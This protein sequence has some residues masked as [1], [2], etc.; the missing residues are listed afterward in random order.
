MSHETI[1]KHGAIIE[2]S[3][4]IAGQN[5]SITNIK[6]TGSIST[7][8]TTV[9]T[10]NVI[11]DTISALEIGDLS[12]VT[13]T[14]LSDNDILVYSA[15]TWKNIQSDTIGETFYTKTESDS[16]FINASGD[17]MTGILNTIGI[18]T[19]GDT[20]ITGNII[21]S[22]N[23]DGVDVSLLNTTVSSHTFNISNPHETTIDNLTDTTIGTKNNLDVLV[24]TAGT[25]ENKNLFTLADDRYINSNGDTIHGEFI[26]D[27]TS[28]T[29]DT[30]IVHGN[31]MLV[32]NLFVSGN[33][34]TTNTN[35]LNVKDNI[36]TI[37]SGE[38][39]NGVTMLTSGIRIDRGTGIP[40]YIVFDETTDTFRVGLSSAVE[41][42]NIVTSG[43]THAIAAREDSPVINGLAYWNNSDRIFVTTSGLKTDSSGNLTGGTYNGVS[44]VTLKS[45]F[46]SHIGNVNP[47]DTGFSDLVTTAHT[48]ITSDVTGL[49]TVISNFN[50]HTAATNPHLTEFSDLIVTAHTHIIDDIS[51]INITNATNEQGLVFS[52][53]TWV[54]KNLDYLKLT[55][56]TLT[57]D[58]SLT[59]L[60]ASTNRLVYVDNT[61]K[62]S[63]TDEYVQKN[64]Y[65][66]LAAGTN[67]LDTFLKTSCRAALWHFF[68]TDGTNMRAGTLSSVWNSGVSEYNET[69]TTD[70]GNTSEVSMFTFINNGNLDLR[71][72]ITGLGTWRIG[73]TRFKIGSSW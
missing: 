63:A 66:P 41:T 46:D 2:N 13:L 28:V 51:D 34:V 45:N 44:V 16:L 32:G 42:S 18:N 10:E 48:H 72:T 4:K 53:G 47:H 40:Y 17:T 14:S 68:I 23:V 33:T 20:N 26:I 31:T 21:I 65:S 29:G 69:S 3:L 15:G 49:N 71:A 55:G 43:D 64:E 39:G 54:N 38:T 62:L 27:G 67:V 8:N 9:V 58:L 59:P 52:A 30:L 22:G 19:T 35:N 1:I 5:S 7:N 57:G 12:A 25:W 73:V 6:N 36:I 70:I 50:S 60:S 61:G 24:F 56:G 37:N 11:N